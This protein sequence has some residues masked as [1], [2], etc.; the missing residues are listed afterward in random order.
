M[1]TTTNPR[2][3]C[4]AGKLGRDLKINI[5]RLSKSR[6]LA[7]SAPAQL[8]YIIQFNSVGICQDMFNLQGCLAMTVA[9]GQICRHESESIML[10]M[11]AS[12]VNINMLCIIGNGN[13]QDYI[14]GS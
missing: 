8:L 13:E 11:A 9:T 10:A 1:Q 3:G 7:S 6:Y 2:F 14:T 12:V 5:N 4:Y